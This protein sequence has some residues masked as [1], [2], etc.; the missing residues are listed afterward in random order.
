R[1]PAQPRRPALRGVRDRDRGGRGRGRPGHRAHSLPPQAH[2]EPR[3]GKGPEGLTRM[4]ATQ[5]ALDN[6]ARFQ[7]E[8]LLTAA[9]LVVV[10]IDAT[11][12]AWRDR[13]NFVLTALALLAA[14]VLALQTPH[15]HF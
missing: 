1:E 8:L 12:A 13:A 10:A 6:A 7:P 14:G 3:R 5:N 9:M 11:R 4:N 2:A 15:A